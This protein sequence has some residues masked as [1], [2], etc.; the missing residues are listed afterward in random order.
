M[1]STEV[2]KVVIA[3]GGTAGW[4]AA[5]ALSKVLGK[6][7]DICLVES[8]D[9]GTV[10]VGEATIPTLLFFN[11]LLGIKE[12]DFL[13]ATHGTFKL[14][15]K[16]ENWLAPDKEYIHAFGTTGKDYWAAGFH[17]F[18]AKG[19]ATGIGQGFG[20]YCLE[21]QAAAAG[22]FA[23][24]PKNGLNYAYHLDATAYGQFLRK[25][26]EA[27]GVKRIEGKITS[28]QTHEGNGFI[29]SLELDSG[30]SVAGD[31]FVDCTGFRGLLI[32]HRPPCP[33]MALED[34]RRWPHHP[35]RPPRT[36]H[37]P[38]AG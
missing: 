28:V 38:M 7:L 10:G 20:D 18:W 25:F 15:I 12:R 24:L 21:R 9:I 30:Q 6:N 19:I 17:N 26:S 11:Q 23:H 29:K 33:P 32:E 4:M 37:P 31:L 8:D 35:L 27:L 3:G 22:K 5:A 1:D 36:P 16:F 13:V 34:R 2:K 14:G